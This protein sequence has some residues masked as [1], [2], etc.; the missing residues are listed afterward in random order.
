ML[1]PAVKKNADSPL[2][3]RTSMPPTVVRSWRGGI[4]LALSGFCFCDRH[5]CR[6]DVG[7][8]PAE[9]A[10]GVE[11]L[12]LKLGSQGFFHR[13]RQAEVAAPAEVVLECAG[14]EPEP[15]LAACVPH[16]VRVDDVRGEAVGFAVLGG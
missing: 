5:A 9:L 15:E 16:P 11:V 13:L 10:L 8:V 4:G 12:V 7:G 6:F 2:R 1:M 3:L 14:T